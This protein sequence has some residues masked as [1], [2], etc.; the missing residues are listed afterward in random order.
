[1]LHRHTLRRLLDLS[2]AKLHLVKLVYASYLQ[3][4]CYRILGLS[5]ACCA[6]L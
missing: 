4:N 2:D 6:S 3:F 5:E 1:M